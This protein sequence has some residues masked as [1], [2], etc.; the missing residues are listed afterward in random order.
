MK[1]ARTLVVIGAGP[2]L[3]MGIARRFGREGYR[4][5][6]IARSRAR[7]DE[8]AAQLA[9]EGYVAQGFAADATDRDQLLA[10][11]DNIEA[12]FGGIDVVEYSPMVDYA[13]VKPVLAMDAATIQQTLDLY[14]FGAMAV[15]ER[16]LPTM[17]K[18]GDGAVLF[19]TGASAA[20]NF[21]S[22]GSVAIAMNA[23]LSY[24]RMLSA[25]LAHEGVFVGSI[26]IAQPI[27]ADEIAEMYWR[28]VNE[29][30][31]AAL[32][33]G[34][35][36]IAEAYEM[37]AARGFGPGFPPGLT[38][39]LPSP[40]SEAERRTFL[41][42]LYQARL[43]ADWHDDPAAAVARADAEVLRLGGDPAAAYYGVQ[44]GPSER[45]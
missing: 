44:I 43:N 21:P 36:E 7:L 31:T 26:V 37:L 38:V 41:L 1:P 35:I 30:A 45:T 13:I 5:A 34:N 16:V 17:R 2:G 40:C 14:L 4:I 39:P 11:L 22:H 12:A 23:L 19:T 33:Y 29:R 8:Y 10:A 28:M 32:I 3:G 15:A 20:A 25:S 27:V 6:L 42:G 18:R 24:T 9:G